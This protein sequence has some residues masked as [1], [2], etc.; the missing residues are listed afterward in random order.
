MTAKLLECDRQW[1]IMDG[2]DELI[3]TVVAKSCNGE[4]E[5]SWKECKGD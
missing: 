2:T 3:L 5:H 1:K 4:A